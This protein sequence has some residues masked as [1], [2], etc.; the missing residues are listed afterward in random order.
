MLA[1]ISLVPEDRKQFGLVLMQ[2]VLKNI[3]LANLDQ[4]ST[5]YPHR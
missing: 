5:W 1:G 2:S 4:F 3:S